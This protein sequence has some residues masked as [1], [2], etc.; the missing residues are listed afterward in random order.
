MTIF[1]KYAKYDIFYSDK[2]YERECDFIEE[3]FRRFLPFGALNILDVG[4]GI[5]SHMINLARRGY[6]VTGIDSSKQM[7]KVAKK[8]IT[9]LKV[10]SELHLM[11]LQNLSLNKVFDASICLFDQLS[12]QGR[13]H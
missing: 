13:R 9:D 5:A 6:N 4:V 12:S 1:D 7:L 3:A 11:D 8:K 2:D 10:Q